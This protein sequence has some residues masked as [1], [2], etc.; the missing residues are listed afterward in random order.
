L[1]TS[2][3]ERLPRWV[4]DILPLFFWMG[5]IFFLSNQPRLIVIEDEV[6]EKLVY[7]LAH[8]LAYAVLAWLWWR[9]LSPNRQATWPVLGMAVGLATLYGVSD[10][11]HQLFVPG[12]HAHIAD[13]LFDLAGALAM[14]LLLRCFQ[15]PRLFPE[16]WRL[17]EVQSGRYTV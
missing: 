5:L 6:S 9:A 8:V 17:P 13:V 14:A 15:W 4:R 16:R 1:I 7:K 12:R 10:E 3:V 11:Y 2:P